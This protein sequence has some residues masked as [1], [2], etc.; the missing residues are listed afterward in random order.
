MDIDFSKYV[1]SKWISE[2]KELFESTYFK[3]LLLYTK[4]KYDQ[5]LAKEPKEF[6]DVFACLDN[7]HPHYT[8]V[9]II[10]NAPLENSNG[11]LFGVKSYHDSN[12]TITAHNYIFK[13]QVFDKTLQDWCPEIF[14]MNTAWF[15]ESSNMTHNSILFK[16][17]NIEIL[18]I[19]VENN[20]DVLI[21]TTDFLGEELVSHLDIP[22]ENHIRSF[23]YD[24]IKDMSNGS[25]LSI[26][27]IINQKRIEN[28]ESPFDF[29]LEARR[30]I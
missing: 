2:K 7:S 12:S 3:E 16:Q 24:H 21:A 17:L 19:I 29:T 25:K 11:L 8:D 1:N 10:G 4:L 15:T 23:G 20:P 22:A 26:Y 14:L 6:K 9:V 30:T 5:G 28:K 27:D 13:H 18:K